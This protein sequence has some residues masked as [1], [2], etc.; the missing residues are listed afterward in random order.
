MARKFGIE[1]ETVSQISHDAMATRFEQNGLQVDHEATGHYASR[2][3]DQGW[4]MKTDGSIRGRGHGL[5]VVSPVLEWTDQGREELKKAIATVKEHATVNRSCGLHVHVSAAGMTAQ[6]RRRLIALWDAFEDVVFT[7]LPPSRRHNHMCARGSSATNRYHALN[8][9]PLNSKGTIEFRCHH[10][11]LNA[12]KILSWVSL[13]VSIMEHAFSDKP[14]PPKVTPRIAA[15]AVSEQVTLSFRGHSYQ[16]TRLATGGFSFETRIFGSLH[17][18]AF[19]II[20]RANPNRTKPV[21]DWFLRQI[22]TEGS[23]GGSRDSMFEVCEV[24]GVEQEYKT[25]LS[26]RFQAAINQW[27]AA[28]E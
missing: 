24:L 7:Y 26:D 8:L 19:E 17:D 1:I 3:Y 13:C 21:S 28:S 4:Q 25:Y 16:A 11:S 14:I 23:T 15:G 5:E 2:R 20:R 9:V 10:A 27:G 12:E 22:V 18:L 6:T